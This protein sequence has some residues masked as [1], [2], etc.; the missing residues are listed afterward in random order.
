MPINEDEKYMDTFLLSKDKKGFIN[1]YN[2]YLCKGISTEN[3]L[4]YKSVALLCYLSLGNSIEFNKLI[5]TVKESEIADESLEIVLNVSDSILRFDF[6]NLKNILERIENNF[7]KE[8]TLEIQRNLMSENESK[9]KPCGVAEAIT[10]VSKDVIDSI[11]D[12]IYIVKN[13]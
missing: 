12:C 1:S 8:F 3:S 10:K 7:L 4:F 13:Y 6:E 2:L 9:D 11:K 5:Q